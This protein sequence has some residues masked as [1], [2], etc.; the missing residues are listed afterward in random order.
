MDLEFYARVRKCEKRITGKQPLLTDI[1]GN[2]MFCGPEPR[3]TSTVKGPQN[4]LLSRGI[5]E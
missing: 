2:S 5:S 1:D 4:I 3:E